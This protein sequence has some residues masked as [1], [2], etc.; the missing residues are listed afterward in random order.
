MEKT[1]MYKPFNIC[2]NTRTFQLIFLMVLSIGIFASQTSFAGSDT[3][4][5]MAKI[6]M[7]VNHYPSDDEK[8]TLKNIVDD[9]STSNHERIMAQSMINLQH[10]ASPAD[11]EKLSQIMNDDSAS[12]DARA[13][14]GIIHNLNHAPNDNDKSRLEK[15]IH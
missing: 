3:I 8:G 15:M 5:A 13:L 6:M 7:N 9:K 1:T 4:Q 14:A 2:K 10:K 11:K 12:A